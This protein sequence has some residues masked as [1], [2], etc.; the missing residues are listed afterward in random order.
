MDRPRNPPARPRRRAAIVAGAIVVVATVG[1][2]PLKAGALAALDVGSRAG[3]ALASGAPGLEPGALRKALGATGA[4][5][6]GAATAPATPPPF[7]PVFTQ[8]GDLRLPPSYQEWVFVGGATG[9]AYGEAALPTHDGAPGTFTHVYLEPGA[10]RHFRDT[11]E[12]PEGTTFALEMREPTGGVSIAT[13]GWF[14]GKS[15][16]VHMAVKDTARLG[17]WAYFNVDR[18]GRARRVHASSCQ[19]CHTEHGAIDNVFV[20]FYPIL[21]EK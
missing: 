17:G 1:Y 4:A 19:N 7:V 2:T 21:T 9:L 5:G 20:Q 3:F 10:F 18:T 6:A 14:A 16:G 8:S 13:D 15:R 12:F 11:G